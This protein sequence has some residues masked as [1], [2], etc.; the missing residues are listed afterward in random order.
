MEWKETQ[1]EP[2]TIH[3]PTPGTG[4]EGERPGTEDVPEKEKQ[5]ENGWS[6][7]LPPNWKKKIK[8]RRKFGRDEFLICILLGIL[9]LVI[10][11]PS[12]SHIFRISSQKESAKS[13]VRKLEQ[14]TDPDSYSDFEKAHS[15]EVSLTSTVTEAETIWDTDA[16]DD[17]EAIDHIDGG[18]EAYARYME[19]KL[20]QALSAMEGAGS[21]KAIVTLSSSQEIVVEK[22]RPVRRTQMTETDASGGSRKTE[23]YDTGEETIYRKEEDGSSLPYIVKM[24]PP[25][26]KG[27]VIIAQGG[28]R[29]EIVKNITESVVALFDIEPH[30]IKVVKMKSIERKEE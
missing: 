16:I 25:T 26:V 15:T 1:K 13:S 30:K 21:V 4:R 6:R 17:I 19:Y 20:E 7:I 24:L 23:E 2:D 18:T 3:P 22:D 29:R 12:D 14:N 27:V 5:S 11:M 28:N 9:C 8:G 10:A